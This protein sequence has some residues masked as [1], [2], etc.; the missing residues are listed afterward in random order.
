MVELV[1]TVKKLM[2]ALNPEKQSKQ[3]KIRPKIAYK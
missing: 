2:L 3:N 1:F